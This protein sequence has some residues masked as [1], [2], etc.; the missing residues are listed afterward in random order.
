MPDCWARA[1]CLKPVCCVKA[2]T[3][4]PV[5]TSLTWCHM[6]GLLRSTPEVFSS[7][8]QLLRL[9]RNELLRVFHDRLICKE[10]KELVVGRLGELVQARYAQH[11]DPVLADPLLFGDYR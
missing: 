7:P 1:D 5:V 11:A 10:D 4:Q 8:G 3:H 9:W 2:H 6:Q